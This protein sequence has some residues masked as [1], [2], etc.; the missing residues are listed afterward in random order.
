MV[1]LK[2][3]RKHYNLGD[4]LDYTVA[5]GEPAHFQ[6]L[7]AEIGRPLNGGPATAGA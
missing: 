2:N 3:S 6:Q 5:A 4:I 7:K 1:L